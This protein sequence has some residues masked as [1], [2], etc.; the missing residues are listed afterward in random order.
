MLKAFYRPQLVKGKTVYPLFKIGAKE[1]KRALV[2]TTLRSLCGKGKTRDSSPRCRLQSMHQSEVSRSN[3]NTRPE[4][5]DHFI[6]GPSDPGMGN[7]KEQSQVSCQEGTQSH[8]HCWRQTLCEEDPSWPSSLLSGMPR[9]WG[10]PCTGWSWGHPSSKASSYQN[11]SRAWLSLAVWGEF[12]SC[13]PDAIYS[14]E[15]LCCIFNR[16][17]SPSAP[18][19]WVHPLMGVR[20][21]DCQARERL[22][23][24]LPGSLDGRLPPIQRNGGYRWDEGHH[25]ET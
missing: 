20:Y 16:L 19:W 14:E 12:T 22:C 5:K 25:W 10:V 3:R 4:A 21:S 1:G 15:Y 24:L 7:S 17:A 6:E 11:I 9:C 8:V 18:A 2:E 13:D 23:A